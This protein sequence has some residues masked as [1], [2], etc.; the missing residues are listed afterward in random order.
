MTD[1]VQGAQGL[2]PAQLIERLLALLAENRDVNFY[3][4]YAELVSALCQGD[5]ALVCTG[6]DAQVLGAFGEASDLALMQAQ[7]DPALQDA[8]ERS[9]YTHRSVRRDDGMGAILLVVALMS[10][11]PTRLMLLLPERQRAH[12][13]EALV[14]ALLVKDLR[15]PAAAQSG[16]AL[17]A[18]VVPAQGEGAVGE[19]ELLKVLALG[20]DVMQA[21]RFGAASL[22]LVNGLLS[23]LGL[24]QAALCWR[25]EAQARLLAV[26][27]LERFERTSP[28]VQHMEAAAAEVLAVDQ[29]IE[30]DRMA[31]ADLV[32]E[33]PVNAPRGHAQLLAS[34]GDARGVMSLPI[35]DGSGQTQAVV[36]CIVDRDW[37]S[38]ELLNNV[39]LMLEMIYPR[40][41]DAFRQDAW[42]GKRLR[43]ALGRRLEQVFGPSKPWA[44]FWAVALGVVVLTLAFGRLPYNVEAGA[45]LATDYTRVLGSQM[46]GRVDE[47]LVTVGEMVKAGQV[48]ARMDT[49]DL[50][51]QRVEVQSEIQRYL[52]EE[53]KA[54]AANALAD[55]QVSRFRRE[56]SQARLSRV[57]YLLDQAQVRAPFDGVVVEGERR[58]LLGASVRRGDQMFRVAQVRDLYIVAQVSEKDVR[59]V[60]GNA[61]GVAVLLSQTSTEIPFS[62]INFVPM[63]Q[64][65]GDKGNQFLLKAQIDG[66]V[67][68]WW[69]PGMTGLAKIEV[70][71]RNIAWILFHSALDTL[72]LKFWW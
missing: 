2:Q 56:Q 7:W 36:L 24:R 5:A 46:D 43:Y 60:A 63:A 44:K 62:V 40:M 26:S 1:H 49:S 72:R 33:S 10:D 58:D 15:Q 23:V 27:H 71:S 67:A 41:A 34:M 54:R 17:S 68:S 31:Q 9:G 14:R 21:R 29:V 69:R 66:E 6:A 28:L 59:E 50:V 70:G 11:S 51:Q 12:L 53:D 42:W 48:M 38:R 55:A 52:A 45:Q 19:G 39:L 64:V 61:K 16:R 22:G 65:K 57:E 32:D 25:T 4:Q 3:E 13:K 18:P 37:P 20:T 8:V 35:R 47:V 30:L